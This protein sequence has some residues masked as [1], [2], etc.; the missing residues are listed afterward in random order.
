[1]KYV[2]IAFLFLSACSSETQRSHP[3]PQKIT[4]LEE[5][6]EVEHSHDTV[7]AT[8]NAKD[9]DTHGKYQL[10]FTTTVSSMKGDIQL[11]EFGAYIWR[12]DGWVPISIYDRPFNPEEFDKWYGGDDGFMLEGKNYSDPDNWL[13]KTDRLNGDTIESLL[14]FTGINEQ[15]VQV[16]GA[17]EIVGILAMKN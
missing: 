5:G 13:G 8:L 15:G 9:P 16:V 7:Y 14:Y 11:K 4:E 10:Q 3:W 2:I 6:I 1:M 17:K 12:N